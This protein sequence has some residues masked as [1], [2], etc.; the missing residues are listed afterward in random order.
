LFLQHFSRLSQGAEVRGFSGCARGRT[1]RI[2][3]G[4]GATHRKP[5]DPGVR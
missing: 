5:H 1:A 3:H 2:L 4:R